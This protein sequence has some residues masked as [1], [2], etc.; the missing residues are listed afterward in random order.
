MS[1]FIKIGGFIT[2]LLIIVIFIAAIYMNRIAVGSG[3]GLLHPG[4]QLIEANGYKFSTKISGNKE[5]IPV[6]MLHG[7]PETSAMWGRLSNEL[8]TKGYYT[9]APDQ[10]G[11]SFRA[12][13]LNTAAY[14]ISHLAADVIAIADAL[15]LDK[16]HLIGHDWGSGVGWQV[17]AQDPDRLLSYSALSI[18][19]LTAFAKAY[20]EDR[21]Q[22]EASNYIR[23]FQIKKIPE[24]LAARNDYKRLSSSF[25][26]FEQVEFNY[27]MDVFRQKNALTG[28]INW[29]RANY[30]IFTG[31]YEIGK[32]SVPVLFMWG[33][34][35]KA[36]L[37][38]GVEMT[39]DYVSDYYKFVEL[40]SGHRIVKESFDEVLEEILEH[41]RKFN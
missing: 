25:K 15:D 34:N 32:I 19:H 6:L 11:Y 18:P 20:E 23:F 5:D 7:F 40:E 31:D 9:I 29:Y 1:K 37:R 3:E 26:N 27:N 8:N 12:R 22:Y 36:V 35:D 39:K 41:L 16:F 33:K 38:S 30:I 28:A 14:H 4:Y 17:A 24:F 21:Q 2:A 10:R 13:P